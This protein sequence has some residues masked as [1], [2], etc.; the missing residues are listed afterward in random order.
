MT[1]E[2]KALVVQ[3]EF[4]SADEELQAAEHLVALGLY[5]V[6]MTR[7]YFAAFHAA[8]ATLFH[9]DLEPRTHGGVLTLFSLHVVKPGHQPP[10]TIRLLARLQKFREQADYGESFVVDEPGASI[11]LAAARAFVTDAKRLVGQ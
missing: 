5:R 9:R 2:G 7:I 3:E 1:S 10:D 8:R 6:A 11:E 4:H